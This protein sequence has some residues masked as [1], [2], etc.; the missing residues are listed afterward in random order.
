MDKYYTTEDIERGVEGFLP[1]PKKV[2]HKYRNEKLLP[3][4]KVARRIYCTREHLTQLFKN[5]EAV[6]TKAE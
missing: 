5:L 6:N 3:Y 1:I 2:Q 4:I